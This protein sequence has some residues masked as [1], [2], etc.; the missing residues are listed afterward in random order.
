MLDFGGRRVGGPRAKLHSSG[1]CSPIYEYR[2]IILAPSEISNFT[3]QTAASPLFANIEIPPCFFENSGDPAT[4]PGQWRI[5]EAR[6]QSM[7][8]GPQ[9][10]LSASALGLPVSRVWVRRE[11]Q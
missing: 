3:Y 9:I 11:D 1:T 4:P 7:N 5:L 8:D 6:A 10:A 2:V